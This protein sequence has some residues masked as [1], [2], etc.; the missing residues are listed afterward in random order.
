MRRNAVLPALMST[1]RVVSSHAFAFAAIGGTYVVGSTIASNTLQLNP[2]ASHAVGGCMAG[3]VAGSR[4][5]FL[6]LFS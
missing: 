1:S 2:I 6:L 3:L 4:S 5:T